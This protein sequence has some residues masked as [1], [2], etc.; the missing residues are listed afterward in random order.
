RMINGHL[1]HLGHHVPR[2]RIRASYER[3][4]GAPAYLTSRPVQWRT[5]H[6]AGPNSLWHHDGQHSL[7]RWRIVIH[8]FIDG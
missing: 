1:R 5:Y 6:V 3:V 2:D 8:A 4:T 7:I